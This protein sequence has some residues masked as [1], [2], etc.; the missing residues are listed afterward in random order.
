[1]EWWKKKKKKKK[2]KARAYDKK[3]RLIGA[4]LLE[5]LIECCDGKSN[6]IKFFSPDQILEATNNFSNSNHL[7]REWDSGYEWYSGKNDKHP[8]ILIKRSS[9]LYNYR[10]EEDF[11]RDIA[12]SSMVSGQKNFLKLVG[13]CLESEYRAMVYHGVKK[14]YKLDLRG[15]PWIR[16][17]KIAEDIATALAYLHTAFPRPFVYR[18]MSL[19]NFLLDE[20][21][22][23]KLW[24][25]SFCVSIPQGET[26][27][28]VN[29]VVGTVGYIDHN[30]MTRLLVS[31]KT[32][33][34]AFG[35]FM[36]NLLIGEERFHK[37]AIGLGDG[38]GYLEMD[39]PE[40]KL[41]NWVS[42]FK[43][44][45]ETRMDV[46][47]DP[48]MLQEMMGGI[49]KQEICRMEAFLMLSNRCIGLR[50]E[51]PTMMEV[52]RE[53]R[54]I[55]TSLIIA[56]SSSPSGETQFDSAQDISFSLLSNQT[57]NT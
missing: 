41:P 51:V 28:Q 10:L 5:D 3:V 9:S 54:M 31:E 39:V 4:K 37:E 25:F 7:F 47:A 40:I 6:P 52:A 13:C 19:S 17:I 1:M 33:V 27:V 12:I 36:L 55:Q 16:R 43:L 15:Q 23:A 14:H 38:Y 50:G 29:H 34:F 46:I 18:T 48:M 2:K 20:D 11:C 21:G 22:V 30:Y 44:V 57:S 56:S 42:K 26:F 45:E 24:D 8:M 53:L 49:S 32:D 35:V